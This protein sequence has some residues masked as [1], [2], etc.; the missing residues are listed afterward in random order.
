MVCHTHVVSNCH[1]TTWYLFV[2]RE[3]YGDN[4]C[5]E[6]VG[7][8]KSIM[9]SRSNSQVPTMQGPGGNGLE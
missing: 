3:Q 1:G 5:V 4:T 6:W 7:P 2:Q 9:A 8:V